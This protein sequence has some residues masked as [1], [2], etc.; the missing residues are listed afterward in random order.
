M[1][2]FDKV[3]KSQRDITKDEIKEVPWHALTAPEQL[4][5]IEEESKERSIAIFKHSTRCG[6]S[7]M[8]L[9]NFEKEYDLDEKDHKIYFLDLLANREISN[10]VADRFEVRHESPQLILIREGKVVHHA[11]HHSIDVEDLKKNR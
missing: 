6:I 2:L 5:K 3:F 10:L 7:R 8:V 4:D 1:G 11:S 9:S